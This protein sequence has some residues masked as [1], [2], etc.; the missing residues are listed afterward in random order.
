VDGLIL[1]IAAGFLFKTSILVIILC[2]LC[3]MSFG[4]VYIYG[5]VLSSRLFGE[6]HS[7]NLRVFIKM[8][9]ILF[10]L[11]PG[12]VASIAVSIVFANTPLGE[13][14]SYLILLVYNITAAAII[15][16]LAKGIFE[17][18]EMR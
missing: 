12:L 6:V 14:G 9:M 15:L 13:Y 10:V 11:I 18:L 1:F 5:N 4:A 7:K 17:K 3:Y 2:A 8:F 16:L